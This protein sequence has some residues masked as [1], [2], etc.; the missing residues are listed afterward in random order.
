MQYDG[1]DVLLPGGKPA[2][3][4]SLRKTMMLDIF[5]WAVHEVRISKYTGEEP[6]EH[7]MGKLSKIAMYQTSKR[8]LDTS[9][10]ITID[11]SYRSPYTIQLCALEAQTLVSHSDL[12]VADP[13][14]VIATLRMG[15]VLEGQVIVTY[16][17]GAFEP[18]W[19]PAVAISTRLAPIT[20]LDQSLLAASDGRPTLIAQSLI[21]SCHA[22]VFVWNSDIED[23]DILT[24]RC[25]LCRQCE[26]DFEASLNLSVVPDENQ[27]SIHVETNGKMSPKKLLQESALALKL[28]CQSLSP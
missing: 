27:V 12:A 9:K 21:A 11:I 24:E 14:A 8:K 3:A 17:C 2:L 16:N 20:T 7:V 10:A 22:D 6:F 15:Q 13:D 4:S 5:T 25:T 18:K 23:M 26:K 1:I 19:S 28:A